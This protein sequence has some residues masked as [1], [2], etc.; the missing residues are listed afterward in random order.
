VSNAICYCAECTP[1][2][3]WVGRP[4]PSGT[5]KV[6]GKEHGVDMVINYCSTCLDV[7]LKEREQ[8][9]LELQKMPVYSGNEGNETPKTK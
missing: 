7:V 5:C 2:H 4:V 8:R 6:C 9:V 3:T 1:I